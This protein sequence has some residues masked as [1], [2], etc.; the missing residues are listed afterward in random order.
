MVGSEITTVKNAMAFYKDFLSGATESDLEKT[1][2]KVNTKWSKKAMW[3][4]IF[5]RLGL[6]YTAKSVDKSIRN[7]CYQAVLKPFFDN[8]TV[9]ERQI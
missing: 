4:Y 2:S 5:A 8:E 7:R 9:F 1:A 6:S 3:V